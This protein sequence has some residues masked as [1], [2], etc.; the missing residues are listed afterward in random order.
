MSPEQ[1]FPNVPESVPKARNFVLDA[2]A[3]VEP[4]ISEAIALMTSELSANAVRHTA[5]Q[6][7]VAVDRSVSQ[8]RVSVTDEGPG[9][10][11]VRT[12][13]HDEPS[14]RGLQIVEKLADDWGV[15][16]GTG[17]GKTVWFSV[18]LEPGSAAFSDGARN[19]VDSPARAT[20]E[21]TAVPEPPPHRDRGIGPTHNARR[22]GRACSRP[23]QPPITALSRKSAK[24][25]AAPAPRVRQ[26]PPPL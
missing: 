16:P 6:F 3:G 9:E 25:C 4:S 17:S 11:I 22:Q 26:L 13:D 8:V 5:S 20:I 2:L 23:A 12:P 10:P 1:A 14:G 18:V 21:R 7:T 19:V 24:I 15:S